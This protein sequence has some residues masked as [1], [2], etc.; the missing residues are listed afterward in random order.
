[1]VD[2]W[3]TW[4]SWMKTHENPFP[5]DLLR[6]ASH[7]FP[8]LPISRCI[9][10]LTSFTSL[11]WRRWSSWSK[12]STSTLWACACRPC[13]VV[14][15]G[16]LGKVTG[17]PHE[18]QVKITWKSVFS[19][20]DF[21]WY[22]AACD[23]VLSEAQARVIA[24][25]VRRFYRNA[26]QELSVLSEM[27]WGLKMIADGIWEEYGSWNHGFFPKAWPKPLPAGCLWRTSLGLDQVWNDQHWSHIAFGELSQG[28]LTRAQEYTLTS[29]WLW[30]VLEVTKMI[31]RSQKFIE[32][33]WAR[34][35]QQ[36]GELKEGK[37]TS[38]NPWCS[39]HC[40]VT[41][42]GVSELDRGGDLR[43]GMHFFQE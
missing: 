43:Q 5:W 30:L 6:I 28:D 11:L 19:G 9:D 27:R 18:N 4:V 14:L 3:D 41:V 22:H 35:G 29:P 10:F 12:P 40:L 34:V 8:L 39:R 15:N 1:M 31:T 32:I 21:T 37:F 7:C 33:H 20:E 42:T 26:L 36:P 38:T 23:L 2:L 25:N 16:L 13:S 17:K 24:A